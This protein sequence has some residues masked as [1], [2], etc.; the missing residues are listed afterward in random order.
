MTYLLVGIGE[1][2]WDIFPTGKELGGAPANFTYHAS[3]LGGQGLIISSVGNDNLGNEMLERLGTLALSCQYVARDIEHPTGTVS[4]KVGAGGE[5]S[6]RIK[7]NVA[8]DFI[9]QTEQLMEL[10]QKVKAITFGTLAQRSEVSRATV[11]A[12]VS[13]AP[14][15]ALCIFD[16]NIRQAFYS[17][18]VIEWSLE[19]CNV[20]KLNEG[21]L[22]LLARLLS[23]EGDELQHLYSLSKRFNLELIAL[24]KGAEGSILY[25][26]EG[27]FIHEGYKTRVVDT[28]GSGDS[29][30][31]ALAL[32]ML[33]GS[34]LGTTSDYA[35]YVSSLVCSRRGATPSLPEDLKIGRWL[36]SL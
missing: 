10:V 5:P 33:T 18:E 20:L 22:Q 12:F 2:L 34:D 4:I 32:G 23:M 25:S 8:W 1:L 36:K 14:S 17:R 31:A 21:E 26:S 29:F 35:N 16:I 30:T 9:P 7:E 28:V 3:A 6:Y 24:T 11:Q 15:D 13:Q 19:A 27:V